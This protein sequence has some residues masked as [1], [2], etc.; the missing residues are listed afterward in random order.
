M[1]VYSGQVYTDA[2]FRVDFLPTGKA[3]PI[4]LWHA[5][6][7]PYQEVRGLVT[8]SDYNVGFMGF[9]LHIERYTNPLPCAT[10][11]SGD[12]WVEP[13]IWHYLEIS[14][15]Q[16]T[17]NVWF[18][19]EELL[20]YQDPDPL[21]PGTIGM[22]LEEGAPVYFDNLRVCELAGPFVPQFHA[23]Q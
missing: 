22:G 17:L 9:G 18:D 21:P 16:G 6:K 7:T 14:T 12:F 15:Y 23:G 11:R 8:D 20:S 5:N 4:F 13:G 1:V 3:Q 19:G 2:V 10:L